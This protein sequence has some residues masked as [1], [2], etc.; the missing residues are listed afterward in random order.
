MADMIVNLYSK[1]EYSSEEALNN[2]GV[3]FQRALAIDKTRICDFVSEN[4]DEICPGW[5]DECASSL[6]R[7]PSSCFIAIK[8]RKIA[9]FACHDAT[10]KGMVGPI[11][12]AKACRRQGI[13]KVLLNKCFEAMKMEGYAY[14]IIGWVSSIEFY[15]KTCGAIA[16]PENSP[17]VHSRMVMAQQAVE[18][19]L[20]R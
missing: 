3:I 5:V 1:M 9:G 4:F 11:G 16:L 13:A 15:E 6:Y 17:G 8:E 20:T 19:A 10:A 14:A 18:G 12:V 2:T 7:Q